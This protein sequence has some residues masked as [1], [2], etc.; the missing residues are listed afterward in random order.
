[1]IVEGFGAWSDAVQE[2]LDL[3][4]KLNRTWVEPCVRNGCIEPC[5][6]GHIRPVVR[7]SAA[8]AAAASAAGVDPGR[9]PRVDDPCKLDIPPRERDVDYIAEAY[10]LSAYIDV[11]TLVARRYPPGTAISY[12]AWCAA[13]QR[14]AAP[15]LDART[16]RWQYERYYN[17]DMQLDKNYKG[18]WEVGDFTFQQ[19]LAGPASDLAQDA[20]P[21]VFVSMLYRGYFGQ[22]YSYPQLPLSPWHTAAV[23]AYVGGV[24][25]GH[26]F[27][28]FHWRSEQADP[29]L[30]L[31]CSRELTR[32]AKEALPP[33]F[34]LA[35]RPRTVLLADM[36]APSNT[37]R[38]WN[39]R[40]WVE[41]EWTWTRRRRS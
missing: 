36:P 21:N 8:S 33:P 1:M 19:T 34:M 32:L 2:T 20:A 13:Y 18:G 39:V 11:A 28:A 12:A 9:L 15:A 23:A 29:E 5:R 24:L 26:P 3:A 35:E 38:M 25:G 4:V 14:D 22:P 27:A 10:P 37:A 41:C 17:F 16:R 31:N 7:W 30:F 6:C 40:A